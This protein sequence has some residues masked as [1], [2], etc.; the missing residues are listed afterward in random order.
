[1]PRKRQQQREILFHVTCAIFTPDIAYLG[2]PQKP[3][4]ANVDG[5][6]TARRQQLFQFLRT[7]VILLVALH[8]GAAGSL[9]LDA[10]LL[11]TARVACNL[12][13]FALEQ[14]AHRIVAVE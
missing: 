2:L 11:V 14:I 12:P 9:L 1:M 10:E 3:A 8:H 5:S 7:E 6:K 4:E 13:P